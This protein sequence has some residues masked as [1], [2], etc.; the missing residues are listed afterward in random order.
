MPQA[1]VGVVVALLSE[2]RA[3]GLRAPKPGLNEG[4]AGGVRVCVSG[5]GD[6]AAAAAAEQLVAR[7][8]RALLSFGTAGGLAS[9]L[10]SGDVVVPDHVLFMDGHGIDVDA[11]W[12]ARLVVACERSGVEL[13]AGRLLSTRHTLLN[14]GIKYLAHTQSQAV[15]VDQESSAVGDVAQAHGL[16]FLV[17]R[18]ICDDAEASLPLAVVD[19]VDAYGRP[20]AGAMIGGLLKAPWQIMKLPGL[21]SSFAAAERSLRAVHDAAPDFAFATAG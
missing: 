17:V 19:G 15:A 20:K 11:A 8:C 13:V 21:A 4:V 10:S 1:Q 5:I 16:P 18:A 3:L 2:A 12:R 14:S 9:A 7:G 6:Q